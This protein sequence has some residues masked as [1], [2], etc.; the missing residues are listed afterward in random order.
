MV[1]ATTMPEFVKHVV[2]TCD[3]LA[4]EATHALARIGRS[5]VPVMT[6]AVDCEADRLSWAA[7][8]KLIDRTAPEAKV[9]GAAGHCTL[10]LG[11][12][13]TDFGKRWRPMADS[14]IDLL[15]GEG[16]EE[17]AASKGIAFLAP[18]WLKSRG[19]RSSPH[20]CSR[21]VEGC[22][23]LV[24]LEAGVHPAQDEAP[25]RTYAGELGVRA[26]QQ[27]IGQIGRAHV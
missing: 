1:F 9:L 26:E 25:L 10:R 19:D 17:Q 18:G 13:P 21:R 5:D 22:S 12:P 24:E 27:P 20:F 11:P 6:F 8:Q 4:A 2:L 16:V 7:L 15:L 14:C 3:A 23:R